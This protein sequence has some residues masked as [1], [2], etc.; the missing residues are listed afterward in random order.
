MAY[1]GEL[2]NVN[3]ES[4]TVHAEFLAALHDPG[5]R[6]KPVRQ[7]K[8]H[9]DD[10][11]RASKIQVADMTRGLACPTCGDGVVPFGDAICDRCQA[12]IAEAEEEDES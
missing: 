8:S 10:Q 4:P 12:E 5:K 6:F 7:Q 2:Y 9:V 1:P 11:G 3:F